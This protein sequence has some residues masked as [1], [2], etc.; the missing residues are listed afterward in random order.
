[1]SN[2]INYDSHALLQNVSDHVICSRGFLFPNSPTSRT[3]RSGTI[4]MTLTTMKIIRCYKILHPPFHLEI[5]IYVIGMC[6]LFQTTL[7]N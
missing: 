3:G 5:H 6:L 7:N 4:R 2:R 1:M